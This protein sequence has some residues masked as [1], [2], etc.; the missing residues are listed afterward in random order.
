MESQTTGPHPGRHIM[1]RKI[2]GASYGGGQATSKDIYSSQ[3]VS[4]VGDAQWLDCDAPALWAGGCR[5]DF[6]PALKGPGIAVSPKAYGVQISN[7]EVYGGN[8]WSP[9]DL[10]T[11][12]LPPKINGMGGTMA[13]CWR[14]ANLN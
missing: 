1:L 9:T 4:M 7:L 14:E 8:C 3:T 10:T 2:G 12:F 11:Y 13:S 5:I 6:D